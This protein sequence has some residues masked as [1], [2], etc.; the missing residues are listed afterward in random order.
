MQ[1]V[2]QPKVIFS[3]NIYSKKSQ[4]VNHIQ[5]LRDILQN[6]KFTNE[7]IYSNRL[8]IDSIKYFKSLLKQVENEILIHEQRCFPFGL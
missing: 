4:L 5:Y 7:I 3:S 8:L 2:I 1:T 6:Q